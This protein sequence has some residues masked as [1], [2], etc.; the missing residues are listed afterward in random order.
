VTDG[1]GTDAVRKRIAR[2]SLEYSRENGSV[3]VWL[4]DGGTEGGR[5]AQAEIEA[6]TE[7][8]GPGE[9][10]SEP[11]ENGVRVRYPPHGRTS[12]VRD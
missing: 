11:A 6:P 3:R 8:T 1:I 12:Q 9:S 10:S 2:G 7:P 4:D 5:E